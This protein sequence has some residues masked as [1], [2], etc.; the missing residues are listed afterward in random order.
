MGVDCGKLMI[1]I[2]RCAIVI[3]SNVLEVNVEIFV[4]AVTIETFDVTVSVFQFL[5]SLA[6]FLSMEPQRM[7]SRHHVL[8]CESSS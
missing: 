4:V 3:V 8:V 6:Y 7:D 1:Y 5:I 2:N